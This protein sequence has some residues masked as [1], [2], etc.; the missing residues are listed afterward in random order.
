[1]NIGQKLGLL[2]LTTFDRSQFLYKSLKSV[3][4]IYRY[5]FYILITVS[6][7]FLIEKV[8]V[9]IDIRTYDSIPVFA[10]TLIIF[11]G[12]FIKYASIIFVMALGA[13]EAIYD[14]DV[15]KYLE[16]LKTKKQFIKDNKLQKWRLRN[17]H[18]FFRV[19]FYIGLWC[20]LY[21]L[22]EDILISAF[23]DIYGHN[24]SKDIYIKF[25]IDYDLTI[26]Y[27]TG[28]YLITI[29]ILDFFVRKNRNAIKEFPT[30]TLTKE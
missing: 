17:M 14:F 2:W 29:I 12:L 19:L 16:E 28:I 1:M 27:F 3:S 30:E 9:M 7:W 18:I 6:L 23:F 5:S 20:F 21:L 4:F 15:D 11:C 24:P 26:K 22:L 25:L 10:Q 13:Y 8:G